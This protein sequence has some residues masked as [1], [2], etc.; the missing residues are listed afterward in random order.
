MEQQHHDSFAGSGTSVG[1]VVLAGVCLPIVVLG[2]N[3]KVNS[4]R[5]SM[6]RWAAKRCTRPR[7]QA[8]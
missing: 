3:K 2:S 5:N 1:P 4:A 6:E 7:S 8:D